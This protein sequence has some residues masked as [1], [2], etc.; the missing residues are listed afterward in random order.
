VA[1]P[2]FLAASENRLGK[3]AEALN[4]LEEFDAS[5]HKASGQ[6]KRLSSAALH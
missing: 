2:L 4:L 1:A 6:T 5:E 3:F